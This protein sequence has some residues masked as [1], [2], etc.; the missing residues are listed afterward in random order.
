MINYYG[1]K[2][3]IKFSIC[4][5]LITRGVWNSSSYK[6]AN[7]I[8]KINVEINPTSFKKEDIVG[9]S[10]NGR[11]RGRLEFDKELV[12]KA[13]EANATIV[14]DN[15]KNRERDYNIGERELA[16]FLREEGYEAEE[17]KDR[18]IWRLGF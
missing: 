14:A 15:E 1:K 16:E 7:G 18:A 10:V 2:D 3:K 17:E 12:K 5:K 11:R 9:V 4:N 8:I 6:Y 13:L